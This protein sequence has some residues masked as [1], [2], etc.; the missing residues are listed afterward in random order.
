MNTIHITLLLLFVAITSA[1]AANDPYRI[2]TFS[3]RTGGTVTV[4]TSGGSIS[5]IGT[6]KNEGRVEMTVRKNGRVLSP[7]ET[8]LSNFTIFIR[9]EGNNIVATAERRSGSGNIW[10]GYNNES[11]SFTVF[12]P[13]G[14]S[15]DLGTSG[16]S[17]R[18][19]NLTGTQ[20]VT[21]SGGSLTFENVSGEIH[22]R[23]SGGSITADGIRGP[24]DVSTSGGS[25]RVRDVEGAMSL[26]TSGGSI[27]IENARGRVSGHTSG[28]SINASFLE[29]TGPID[30]STSGGS[31]TV[32]L[33][34]DVGFNLDARG[35]RV[36]ADDVSFSGRTERDRM[37][38][39]VNGGGVKVHLRTTA[40]TIRIK[41]S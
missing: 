37:T 30:M 29:V 38:G 15:S 31:V 14:Y 9:Q 32:S 25:I 18:V 12:V 26:R 33:P 2:E 16:G 10:S 34:R 21:T 35:N 19:S 20:R 28:G 41:K 17:I 6:T 40:G 36:V 23:T 22:G 7:S 3:V 11:V 5:V 24:F 27:R 4:R 1:S 8:D 39:A 13:A